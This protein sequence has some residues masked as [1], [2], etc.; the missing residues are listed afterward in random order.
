MQV[1]RKKYPASEIVL[2]IWAVLHYFEWLLLAALV[3]WFIYSMI[4]GFRVDDDYGNY[5]NSIRSKSWVLEMLIT[6]GIIVGWL[7]FIFGSYVAQ[8]MFKIYLD[9][10]KN[11]NETNILLTQGVLPATQPRV[12]TTKQVAPETPPK[13]QSTTHN[14]DIS[15]EDLFS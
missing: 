1:Q 4:N 2:K 14:T 12:Q 15:D 7:F 10:A 6:L 11:T 3:I 9:I 5:S 8:E 13:P